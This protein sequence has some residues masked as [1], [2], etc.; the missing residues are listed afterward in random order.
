M[1]NWRWKNWDNASPRPAS[2]A[3]TPA[4]K[5]SA[6]HNAGLVRALYAIRMGLRPEGVREWNYVINL[7]TKGRYG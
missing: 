4:E 3:L 5:E 1:N 7:H 6:A 2:T